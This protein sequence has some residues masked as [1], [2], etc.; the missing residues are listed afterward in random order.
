M[1]VV[2]ALAGVLALTA[3]PVYAQSYQY[4]SSAAAPTIAICTNIQRDLSY[5]SHGGEVTRL[6][7]FLAAQQTGFGMWMT[8]GYYGGATTAAVKVFQARHGLA[9]TGRADA[10]TRAAIMRVSCGYGYQ[11]NPT[12]FVNPSSLY[13]SPAVAVN[14]SVPTTYTYVTPVS[15]IRPIDVPT[16]STP[17]IDH[18]TGPATITRGYRGVWTMWIYNPDNA[19]LDV[20]VDWDDDSSDSAATITARGWHTLTFDHVYNRAGS[21]EI[22]IRADNGEGAFVTK[23]VDVTVR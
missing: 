13:A 7:A 19:S 21:R 5:G 22:V 12:P 8:T 1:R 10:W 2:S 17:A 11:Y 15:P 23:N 6:Q 4:Y 14:P 16:Y 20:R 3:T 9:Q 18:V